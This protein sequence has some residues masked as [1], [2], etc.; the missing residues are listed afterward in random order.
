MSDNSREQDDRKSRLQRTSIVIYFLH[1]YIPMANQ[2]REDLLKIA[3]WMK[4]ELTGEETVKELHKLIEDNSE[5][6]TH[7]DI[8]DLVEEN[9]EVEE[10]VEENQ[11]PKEPTE[12]K[13]EE[14]KKETPLK[15][16]KCHAIMTDGKKKTTIE[17]LDTESKNATEAREKLMKKVAEKRLTLLSAQAERVW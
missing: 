7:E 5:D 2:K 14:K 17:Y 9:Q 1:L 6:V 3:E 4:L 10:K 16:Y 8:E 13:K 11:E 15:S 12:K